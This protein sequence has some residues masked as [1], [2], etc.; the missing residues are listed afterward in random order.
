MGMVSKGFGNVPLKDLT[1]E[2]KKVEEFE[3]SLCGLWMNQSCFSL[4]F[5]S[6]KYLWNLSQN[7]GYKGIYIVE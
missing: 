5:L 7:R 4:G 1:M 6:Q 2:R 3:E